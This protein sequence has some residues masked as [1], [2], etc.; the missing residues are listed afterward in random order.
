MKS[1][2]RLLLP[3]DLIDT[4]LFDAESTA[5]GYGLVFGIH[6]K[7]IE[8]LDV[9]MQYQT[10]VD[11]EYKYDKLDGVPFFVTAVEMEKGD[12]YK[13]DIPAMLG[14]G[15]GYQLLDKLY[16]TLSFNYYF[17]SSAD[18]ET[19]TMGNGKRL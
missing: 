1:P 6:V 4:V 8:K 13:K 15:V 7:P 14:A 9:A 11:L 16:T 10:K 3:Q 19:G 12:K 5:K 18:F 2:M 17:N